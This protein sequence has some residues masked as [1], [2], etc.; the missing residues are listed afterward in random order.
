MRRFIKI[1][2][3]LVSSVLLTAC[4]KEEVQDKVID[5]YAYE[6]DKDSYVLE[7]DNLKFTLDPNTTYFQVLDKKSNS[8]W[9]SNPVDGANDPNSD[10]QSAKYLQSTLLIEYCDE[11]GIDTIFNNFQYSIMNQVYTIEQEDD[12]IKVNYTI[13]DVDKVYLLPSAVPESR[14]NIFLDKMDASTQKKINSY[15][16]ILDINKLRATDNK[17]DLLSQYPDLKTSRIYVLRDGTQDYL[18]KKIEALF[19]VAGYN[20]TEYEEDEARYSAKAAKDNPYFNISVI[21]RLDKNDLMVE[22][23]FENMEWSNKY[24]L[25]KVNVLPFMGAGSMKDDGFILVPEGN[26]GII[27]FNNGKSAQSSYYTEVYGWDDGV[28]RKYVTDEKKSQFPLFGIQKNGSSMMCILEDYNSV[29]SIE[30][31]VSGKSHS[32]NYASAT[33]TTLHTASLNVSAKTDKAVMV[34][35]AKKPIGVIKQRYRFLDTDSYSSMAEAYRNY[36]MVKYPELDKNEEASTPINITLVGAIDEVKQR[37]GFPVS[38]PVA[39]TSYQEADNILKELIE[40]GYKNLSIRY[41]AWMNNGIKQSIPTSIKTISQLGSKSKLKKFLN[42]AKELGVPV[43]LE[44]M[45]QYAYNFGMFDGFAINRDS[46]KYSSKEEVK[47]YDFSPIYFGIEDWNDPYYLL[48]PQISINSIE[49]IADYAKK[50]SAQVAF[51]DVGHQVSAD[52]NPK[53]LI[54]RQQVIDMQVTAL[55]KVALAGTDIMVNGG[56]DYVLPY[57]DFISDMD[58]TGSQFMILDYMVPFY[59]MAIHGLVE[60]SGTSL[61]LAGDYQNEILKSA[62]SGAGLSFTFMKSSAFTLKDS[63][64]TYLFGADYEKWKDDAYEIY[65]RYDDELGHCNNQY[66]TGH[67]QLVKGVFVT[68]YEDGTKV[69]VNY[70]TVDYVNGNITI[71]AKDYKV[72]RR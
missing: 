65:S 56:N 45:M 48:K 66:I 36:L 42:S 44:G 64:Y 19:E 52:Y 59:T 14:M 39:L 31:G 43:Y 40:T 5:T 51:S 47:L 23:P 3:I 2:L 33:Y 41:S 13:G 57:V 32:Y 28:Q 67:E 63:N 35:E 7:N 1:G 53:N 17:S 29:A 60:Y 6:Q 4:A 15:Y 46:A 18:K 12:Y 11:T 49:N 8:T 54:T 26:G 21:Y 20:R 50:N 37:F 70:N 71:L 9:E 69:Y 34:Y 38:M 58:L 61:N 25:T 55:E 30:A 10:A 16:R 27:N 22:L 72:V 68:S 24:P 62:E